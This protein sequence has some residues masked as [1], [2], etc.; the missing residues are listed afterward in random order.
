MIIVGKVSLFHLLLRFRYVIYFKNKVSDWTGPLPLC[1]SLE[2]HPQTMSI[3]LRISSYTLRKLEVIR[4]LCIA[5]YKFFSYFFYVVCFF[6]INFHFAFC[7]WVGT[8]RWIGLIIC[9]CLFSNPF[10]WQLTLYENVRS[11][12][13]MLNVDILWCW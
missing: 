12:I 2:I 5:K 9:Q 8:F 6:F 7:L 11:V 10:N 13:F 1:L 3:L 4:Y